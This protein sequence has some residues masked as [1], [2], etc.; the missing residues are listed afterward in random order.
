MILVGTLDQERTTIEYSSHDIRY[1]H[2]IYNIYSHIDMYNSN[3]N[4]I[5]TKKKETT[6]II[7]MVTQYVWNALISYSGNDMT[8]KPIKD[9]K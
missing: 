6:Q 9:Y 4:T 5:W 3:R 2:Y 1:T 8:M 7:Y